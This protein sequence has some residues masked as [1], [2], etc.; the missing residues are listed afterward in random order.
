MRLIRAGADACRSAAALRWA[1]SASC[2]ASCDLMPARLISRRLVSTARRFFRS[3]T[4]PCFCLIIRSATE[5]RLLQLLVRVQIQHRLA[6]V[7]LDGRDVRF[8]R[9]QL[10]LEIR[11]AVLEGGLGRLIREPRIPHRLLD[12]GVA[13]FE[14]HRARLDHRAGAQQD[15]FDPALLVAEIQRMSS[16][17]S[18]PEPRTCRSIC[19]RL[20]VSIQ[21]VARSTL[22]A[23]GLSERQR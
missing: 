21:T 5:A 18:V 3:A 19:P 22:G 2:G 12:V 11:F 17:T 16:G 10:A 6:V 14:D 4:A 1:M 23:A 9:Q 15:A 20:T 13:Q 8:L 7:R